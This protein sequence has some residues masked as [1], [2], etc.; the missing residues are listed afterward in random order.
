V[1]CTCLPE[2]QPIEKEEPARATI[3]VEL[4]ATPIESR[5]GVNHVSVHVVPG[6]SGVIVNPNFGNLTP[7][8]DAAR[9]L[10]APPEPD[11]NA[12]TIQHT[13]N[14]FLQ[15]ANE[16]AK[17]Q[18]NPLV[19]AIMGVMCELTEVEHAPPEPDALEELALD[20]CNAERKAMG[21]GPFA[22]F[23]ELAA[24]SLE[25]YLAAARV[26]QAHADKQSLAYL[27]RAWCGC[28]ENN[29]CPTCCVIAELERGAAG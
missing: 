25:R 28:T 26:A 22:S 23:D 12:P 3:E 2:E 8:N 11:E 19:T 17:L 9:K 15:R 27:K 14:D 24:A 1:F 20:I 4:G 6:H 18:G 10:L 7:L 16:I 5:A 13:Y 29:I 21:Y